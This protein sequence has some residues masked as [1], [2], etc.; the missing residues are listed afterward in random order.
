[1]NELIL[2]GGLIR[3]PRIRRERA[4][5]PMRAIGAEHGRQQH[6]ERGTDE[7][8]AM[9]KGHDVSTLDDWLV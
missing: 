5:Q 3:A 1:M 8:N 6:R 7:Q 4:L 2:H 9:A